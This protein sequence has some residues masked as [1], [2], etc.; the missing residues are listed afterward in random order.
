ER[1]LDDGRR[2]YCKR[3][4]DAGGV[5]VAQAP[6]SDQALPAQRLERLD[7]VRNRHGRIRLVRE[8]EID[9][10]DTEPLEARRQLTANALGRQ[11]RVRGVA[12]NGV[13]DLG[14]E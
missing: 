5:V 10:V 3:L 2:R 14:R 8:I 6:R 13:E 12:A 11:P 1:V 4:L 9:P 7:G